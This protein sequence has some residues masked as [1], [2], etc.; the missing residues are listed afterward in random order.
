M[1]RKKT[2]P[3]KPRTPAQIRAQNENLQPVH[4]HEEAV[5]RGRR[6]GQAY[7]KKVKERQTMAGALS[8]LLAMPLRGDEN[9]AELQSLADAA[10]GM[11]KK[12]PN[13]TVA[14]AI[15]LAQIKEA[16]SGS[17]RAARFVAELMPAKEVEAPDDGLLE[18]LNGTAAADWEEDGDGE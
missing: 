6:G 2:T 18:A 7:A 8:A 5:E 17:T 12:A 1:P 11:G 3:A 10:A 14:E 9:L 16:L 15:L 13:V 4:T